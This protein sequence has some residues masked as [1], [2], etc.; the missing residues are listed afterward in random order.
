[1]SSPARS[2]PD[3]YDIAVVALS[4]RALAASARKAGLSA[5]AI[6]LFADA[7][8]REHA[9][10]AVCARPSRTGL[11]FDRRSLPGA[12]EAHAPEGLPVVL[13]TGFEHAPALMRAI[14]R[15]NPIAG[16]D[17]DMVATL[18]DP[19]RFDVLL[20]SL[21]IPHPQVGGETRKEDE[22]LSKRVGASGGAHIRRGATSAGRGRYLQTYV[23]GRS[24]SAL[25]LADGRRAAIL[26]F[27]EQWTDPTDLSPFRYGGAVGPVALEDELSDA[28]GKAL[29][30]IV[31]AT[32]LV[33]LA[34]ADLILPQNGDAP[35]FMLLEINPRPGATLDVFDR[36]DGPSLL[37]LHLEACAGRLPQGY[38]TPND[39]RAAATVYADRPLRV[40]ARLRPLWTAD[41]PSCDETVPVGAPVCTVLAAAASP[42]AAR[43]L[44]LERRAALLESLGAALPAPEIVTVKAMAPA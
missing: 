1:M 5:L 16:A 34:S 7:D 39:A 3:R 33:G 9:A 13:G 8:T 15:R 19:K 44:V 25:F 30:R 17:A 43:A 41:W 40:A 18:K 31:A 12:L 6:D 4:A 11:G 35:D 36:D 29:M 24:V 42:P 26:G 20:T 14:A 28:I 2:R 22:Q 10:L 27:S 23:R 32:G 38:P 21:S 37:G